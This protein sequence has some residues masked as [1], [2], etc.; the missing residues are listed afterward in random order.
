MLVGHSD[1]ASISLLYAGTQPAGLEGILIE[2]P[3]VFVEEVTRQGVQRAKSGFAESSWRPKLERLHQRGADA[4]FLDWA[5]TWLADWFRDWTIVDLLADVVCPLMLIQGLDDEYGT[6][7]QI[8]AIKDN[9]SGEVVVDLLDGCGHTPHK[10]QSDLV[11][12]VAA[13]FVRQTLDIRQ[14]DGYS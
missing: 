4:V 6:T 10:E 8:E 3:H 1:G 11:L 9:V 14:A 2:A 12:Q 5:D 7:E 13:N